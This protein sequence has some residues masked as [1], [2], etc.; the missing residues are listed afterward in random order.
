M[1]LLIEAWFFAWMLAA[2]VAVR[3]FHVLLA[4]T[5]LETSHKFASEE[6]EEEYIYSLLLQQARVACLSQRV[7]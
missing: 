7:S 1:I 5:K 6:A 4:S 3:W 2:V